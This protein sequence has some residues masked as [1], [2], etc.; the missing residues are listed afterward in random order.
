MSVLK[1][2]TQS[3]VFMELCVGHGCCV[4]GGDCDSGSL[5]GVTMRY[6]LQASGSALRWQSELIIE[7]TL[8]NTLL[9]F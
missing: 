3:L 4:N 6:T 2:T 8:T 5:K 1:K 9:Y 7:Y